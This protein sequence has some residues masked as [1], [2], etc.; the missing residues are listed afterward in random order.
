VKEYVSTLDNSKFQN[1]KPLQFKT[2]YVMSE[3]L[4]D[5]EGLNGSKKPLLIMHDSDDKVTKFIGSEN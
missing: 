5:I 3:L 2:A 4:R 1:R